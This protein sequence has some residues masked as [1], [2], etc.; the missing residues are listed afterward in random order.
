VT[1][2]EAREVLRLGSRDG[3]EAWIADAVWIPRPRGGEGWRV[4]STKDGWTFD[5]E[6]VEG[7]VRVTAF[8]P[9]PKPRPAVWVVQAPY[10]Q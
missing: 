7:A 4:A 5:L 3:L 8:P 2:K 10:P 1:E 6:P 9:G